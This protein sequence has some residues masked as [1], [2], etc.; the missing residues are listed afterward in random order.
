MYCAKSRDNARR[1]YEDAGRDVRN[2]FSAFK[3]W[4]E[5]TAQSTDWLDAFT[6]AERELSQRAALVGIETLD[7]SYKEVR[8]ASKECGIES[9][10]ALSFRMLS[11][12]AHPTAMQI[13]ASRDEERDSRQ[14][15]LFFSQGCLFFTGA[16]VEL[17]LIVRKSS[18]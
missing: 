9:H 16:F 14:R 15:D 10:Y 11:K 4:G 5:K 2:L 18:G 8:D 13:L 17:E 3:A 1:F 12:F 6:S 7:R